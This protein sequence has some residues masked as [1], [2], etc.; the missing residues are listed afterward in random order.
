VSAVAAAN[1]HT[2]VVLETGGPAAMPWIGNVSAA[3]EVWYPG[4]MG[5]EALA[6]ILFG[7]VN[8]TGKLPAT[9]AKSDA[10]LPHPT[11]F[12]MR[13]PAPPTPPAAPP[14]PGAAPAA[15]AGRG[16]AGGGR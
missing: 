13:P 8:P 15:P 2:I 11:I 5:H 3:L 9:F 14:A 7:D 16:G 6:N 12:G 4:T 10:D 1:P